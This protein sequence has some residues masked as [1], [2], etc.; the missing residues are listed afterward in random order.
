MRAVIF[1][2]PRQIVVRDVPEPRLIDPMDALVRVRAAAV[3]GSDL[4]TYR[5]MASVAPGS[6]IGHEFLGEVVD[7]GPLV[8][9]V[10]VGD[11]VV[12]PFRYSDG[13]CEFCR[14]GLTSSCA[15]GGFWGREIR[16][17]GQGELVRVPFADSTLVRIGGGD[18]PDDSMTADLLTLSDVYPTG[19]HA[20]VRAGV[21][22]HSCVVVIGDGAVGLSAVMAARQRG[23][24]QVIVLGSTHRD[25][26][27]LALEV[28][29]D[30][31]ISARGADAVS[32]VTE[33]TKGA[34]ASHVVEC[35]GTQQSFDTAF[36]VARA[37]GTVAY[38]GLPHGVSV[39]PASLFARNIT[40]TGGICP[41]R[42]YMPSLMG[43]VLAGRSHPGQVFTQSLALEEA[44]KAYE[45]M[46]QRSAIKCLLKVGV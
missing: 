16:D 22:G 31:F 39:D 37:G 30:R 43:E 8:D 46:D 9:W 44:S 1:D 5:G 41:A 45:L 24:D 29:A 36:S 25:R 23:V 34:L 17:A 19:T 35:V 32:A 21:D 15:H 10:R 6:R 3:C 12:A 4:W 20:V 2:G 18:K 13:E 33:I 14:A 38:V 27:R 7:V 11:W 28:G 42:V 40:L 26:Q